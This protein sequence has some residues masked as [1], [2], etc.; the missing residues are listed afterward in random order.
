VLHRGLTSQHDRLSA[1]VSAE[2]QRQDESRNDEPNDLS[3]SALLEAPRI[4]S[5]HG[6]QI[7]QR[8]QRLRH[9]RGSRVGHGNIEANG[10]AADAITPDQWD[11]GKRAVQSK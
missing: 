6:L 11:R 10:D 2:G 9:Q 7:G 8:L 5:S 1:K 4:G 3:D